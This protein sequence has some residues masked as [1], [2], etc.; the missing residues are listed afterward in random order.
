[1]GREVLFARFEG[2]SHGLSRSG[3][4]KLRQERLRHIQA[5]FEKHL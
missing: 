2:Q 3:H 4:P 5:W 1:M